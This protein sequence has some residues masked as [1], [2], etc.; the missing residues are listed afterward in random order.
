MNLETLIPPSFSLTDARSTMDQLLEVYPDYDKAYNVKG[1]SYLIE[2]EYTRNAALL[3]EAISN[4]SLAI[5]SN[6]KFYS[7]YYNLGL[8]YAQKDDRDN[9]EFNLKQAIRYNSRF[10]QAYLKLADLYDFYGESE[11]ARE[12]RARASTIA[13]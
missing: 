3:D 10:K 11:R 12:V 1:Y 13:G 4:I 7:G 5:S 2:A 6:Y 8:C 9:A